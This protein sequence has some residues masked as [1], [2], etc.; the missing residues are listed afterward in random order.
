LDP[1]G[2]WDLEDEEALAAAKTL[3]EQYS[4]LE[5]VAPP[6]VPAPAAFDNMASQQTGTA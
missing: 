4:E 6:T 2:V 1:A 3:I 5:P